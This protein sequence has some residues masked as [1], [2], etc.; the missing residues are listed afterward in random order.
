MLHNL[1]LTIT[2]SKK[3]LGHVTSPESKMA[4]RDVSNSH[5]TD[6]V[7]LYISTLF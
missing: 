2:I 5:C 1:I 4:E 6:F 3:R 7:I